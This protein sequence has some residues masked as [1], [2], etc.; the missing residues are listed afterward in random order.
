MNLL[1]TNKCNQRCPYCFLAGT[2]DHVDKAME[3]IS[4]D[5][6]EI[7]LK[8]A[9][10]FLDF[11]L[12]KRINLL[13]GEPT[14]HSRFE[15]LLRKAIYQKTKDNADVIFPVHVFSN[16]LFDIDLARF[17]AKEPCG[18]LLNVNE[19]AFY[20]SALWDKLEKTLLK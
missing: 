14:L 10:E 20:P 11:G 9:R 19:P 15:E 13:G 6:F 8:Y 18:L 1:L 4:I 5:N 17:L 7:A 3:E 12:K 16:G 2:L